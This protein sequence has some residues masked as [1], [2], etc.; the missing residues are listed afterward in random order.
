VVVGVVVPAVTVDGL[1]GV[2]LPHPK[3]SVAPAAAPI[4]PSAARRVIALA[5]VS[6]S[7]VTVFLPV[8]AHLTARMLRNCGGDLK[9]LCHAGPQICRTAPTLLQHLFGIIRIGTS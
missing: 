7:W 6:C 8:V 9:R 1:V 3:A 2:S 5:S 4:A